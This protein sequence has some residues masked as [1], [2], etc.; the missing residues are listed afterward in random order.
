MTTTKSPARCSTAVRTSVLILTVLL[1]SAC[2]FKADNKQPG[3]ATSPSPT[4]ETVING[5]A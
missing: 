5:R 1:V 3:D 2:G 4:E